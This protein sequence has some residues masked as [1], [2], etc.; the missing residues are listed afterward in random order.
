MMPG[1][2]S[3]LRNREINSSDRLGGKIQCKQSDSL[4]MR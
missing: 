3:A 2:T 1:K 4:Q